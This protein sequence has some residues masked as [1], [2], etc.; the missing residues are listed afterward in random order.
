MDVLRCLDPK[1]DTTIQTEAS[2][3]EL[4]AA[5]LQHGKPICYAS[6]ALTETEHKYSNIERETLGVVWGL[7]KFHYF[8]FYLYAKQ[9]TLPTRRIDHKPLESIFKKLAHCLPRLHRFLIT[10]LKY[11][12]NVKYV[13]GSEV[14]IADALSRVI[15]QP[16]SEAD[17]SHHDTSVHR[18]TWTLPASAIKLR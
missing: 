2:Q 6:R 18:I 11:D 13:K 15:S 3:K 12:V 8:I 16:C 17:Q 1:T 14:P 5:L 7:E 9:C 4:E 10:G